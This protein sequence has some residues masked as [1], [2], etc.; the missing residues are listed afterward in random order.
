GPEL[1]QFAA[2]EMKSAL[3][4]QGDF[5]MVPENEIED[6]DKFASV[7]GT[8]NYRLIFD[9]ARQHGAIGVITGTIEDMDIIERGDE[10]G[11]FQTRYQTVNTNVRYSFYDATSEK[12]IYTKNSTAEVTEEHTRF[13]NNREPDAIDPNRGQSAVAK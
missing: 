6:A 9:R 3:Q 10:V 13:F 4:R 12:L 8:F 2:E 1:G 5:L 7:S 11:L